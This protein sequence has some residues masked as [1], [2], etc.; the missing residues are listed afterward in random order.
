MPR[1]DDGGD[2]GAPE[3][4]H[5]GTREYIDTKAL[6]LL[7]DS[8]RL[9]RRR[10]GAATVGATGGKTPTRSPGSGP[11]GYRAAMTT[12]STYHRPAQ[13]VDWSVNQ[14]WAVRETQD[15]RASHPPSSQPDPLN[16]IH[17]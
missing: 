9:R 6:L 8:E 3:D 2:D 12:T 13:E 15:P 1:D 4:G 5:H 17:E 16:L 7:T 10:D 11:S 14:D